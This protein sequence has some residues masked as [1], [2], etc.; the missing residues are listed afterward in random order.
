MGAG[1]F[2]EALI[3]GGIS[4]LVLVLCFLLIFAGIRYTIIWC[5]QHPLRKPPCQH[6]L[7]VCDYKEEYDCE[8]DN[9]K[10]FYV[11]CTKCGKTNWVEK[12]YLKGMSSLGLYK[13]GERYE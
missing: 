10:R 3:L 12:S 6:N 11:A 9:R 13:E 7:V 2:Y 5:R 4:L 1:R 8:F